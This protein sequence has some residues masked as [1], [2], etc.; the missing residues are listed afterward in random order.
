MLYEAVSPDGRKVFAAP[1]GKKEMIIWEAASPDQVAAWQREEEADAAL[2][3]AEQTKIE[4]RQ[5]KLPKPRA[6]RH[7]TDTREAVK[8][9]S[10]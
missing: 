9:E 10:I 5:S 2:W 1:G 6:A 4:S 8:A 3:A 7:V